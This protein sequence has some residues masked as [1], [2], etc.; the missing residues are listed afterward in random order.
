[1]MFYKR[2]KAARSTRNA[3]VCDNP[4][5]D[6]RSGA[7]V[8]RYCG[9]ARRGAAWRGACWVNAAGV[10]ARL[11]VVGGLVFAAVPHRD[12]VVFAGVVFAK[13]RAYRQRHR[14]GEGAEER[15]GGEGEG[16]DDERWGAVGSGAMTSTWRG[17]APAPRRA[18]RGVMP[19][20]RQGQDTAARGA[21]AAAAGVAG[22]RRERWLR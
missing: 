11:V 8:P 1:M 12:V 20:C 16:G 7:A 14:G 2:I 9:A 4:A 13:R 19:F 15:R 17:P 10:G 21:G 6:G 22:A 3:S 5:R 18:A